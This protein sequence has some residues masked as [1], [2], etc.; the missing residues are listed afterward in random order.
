MRLLRAEEASKRDNRGGARHEVCE[1]ERRKP[2]GL[3][4]EYSP[5]G[6]RGHERW[7]SISSGR[8]ARQ[9]IRRC[10]QGRDEPQ[11]TLIHADPLA[12]ARGCPLS[13]LWFVGLR[14]PWLRNAWRVRRRKRIL[15]AL[16]KRPM[17]VVLSR[18]SIS[19]LVRRCR[20]KSVLHGFRLRTMRPGVIGEQGKG[21]AQ[22]GTL[23]SIRRLTSKAA[24][25]RPAIH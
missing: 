1:L 7:R 22:E 8:L 25:P 10:A 4:R 18:L 14:F 17:L 11:A 24:D 20:I 23:F 13:A 16:V 19:V 2:P 9:G 21:S 5:T 6:R 15:A 3:L 12:A